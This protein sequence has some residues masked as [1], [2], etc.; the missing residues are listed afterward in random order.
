MLFNGAKKFVHLTIGSNKNITNDGNLQVIMPSINKSDIDVIPGPFG[1]YKPLLAIKPININMN[2][3]MTTTTDEMIGNYEVDWTVASWIKLYTPEFNTYANVFGAN[4]HGVSV[5]TDGTFVF[6]DDDGSDGY[7]YNSAFE[8]K[9]WHYFA[10]CVSSKTKTSY[11]FMDGKLVSTFQGRDAPFNLKN[12]FAMIT[13]INGDFAA[14]CMYDFYFSVNE[15]KWTKDFIPPKSIVI[16]NKLLYLDTSNCVWSNDNTNSLVK[17]ANNWASLSAVEKEEILKKASVTMPSISELGK[18]SPF[19]IISYADDSD[20]LGIN[21][22]LT[23]VPKDQVVLPANL[24]DISSYEGI[25]SINIASTISPNAQC[26]L[27][28]TTDNKTYQVYDAPAKKWKPI[29]ATAPS[30]LKEGM[31]IG[32]L[33]LINRAAWD[34]L[35]K[36]ASGIGLAYCL[37]ISEA[38]DN[39]K[40]DTL[41]LNVD[42]KGTWVG[43][44]HGTDYQYEY[45]NELLTV[46]ILTDGSYKINYV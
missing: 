16:Q 34:L 17:S 43:A 29:E 27:A 22:V 20:F 14:L 30:M 42:M 32:S 1:N 5:G 11:L 23:G 19:K 36:D 33:A 3:L 12:G 31:T 25:N 46:N 26:R 9:K 38:T 4:D 18:I 21:Y 45:S 6:Y 37:S 44:I 24:L 39:C 28:V 2:Y 15:C 10:F 8:G 40:I 35:T 7:Y 41:T 13:A